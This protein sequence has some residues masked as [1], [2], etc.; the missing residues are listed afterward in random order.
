MGIAVGIIIIYLVNYF[1][2][3]RQTYLLKCYEIRSTVDRLVASSRR[4]AGD[5]FRI[6]VS[7]MCVILKIY[8]ERILFHSFIYDYLR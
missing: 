2:D 3:S 7:Q 5:I 1:T 4:V 6:P 8:I